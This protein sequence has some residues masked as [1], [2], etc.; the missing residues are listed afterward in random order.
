MASAP[1]ALTGALICAALGYLLGAIPFGLIVTRLAG[2]GDV[3]KIGSGNIGATNVLRTGK[4]W[5]AALTLLLDGGK[6]A[7]AVL[8]AR[9]LAAA[10]G[11]IEGVIIAGIAVILGHVFPVWL[12][13]K[14]GKGFATTLGVML[15]ALW[16]AGLAM[17]ATWLVA[18]YFTRYSSL[19]A[20]TA[21]L[22]GPFY[23]IA[24]G[25]L[26]YAMLALAL[27]VIVFITHRHNIHRLVRGREPH[28]GEK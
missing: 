18:A 14:G 19:S 1:I 20:L 5:A 24:F 27:T 7:A 28:I 22:L 4:K 8:I 2:L 26:S 13:F 16:P 17:I 12:K 25:D 15:G 11:A 10:D 21:A 3:R 9:H 6:G 23:A